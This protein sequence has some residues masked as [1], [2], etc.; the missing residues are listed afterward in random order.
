[1]VVAGVAEAALA[2]VAADVG[3]VLA[4]AA[5]ARTEKLRVGCGHGLPGRVLP[6]AALLVD[7][8]LTA[9]ALVRATLGAVVQRTRVWSTAGEAFCTRRP[10][11]AGR[12]VREAAALTRVGVGLSRARLVH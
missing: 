6:E 11:T 5:E 3:E 8:Q 2:G 10:G 4:Q 9:L 1:M 7:Q 12:W